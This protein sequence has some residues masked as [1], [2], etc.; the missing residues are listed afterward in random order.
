LAVSGADGSENR[1]Y[2]GDS[3]SC[4]GGDVTKRRGMPFLKSTGPL[5]N[6][7]TNAEGA[8]AM[9]TLLRTF[10]VMTTISAT[11]ARAQ[12]YKLIEA[13]VHEPIQITGKRGNA[14]LVSEADWANIQ[15]TLHLA[16][17]PGMGASIRRG[18]KEPLKKA[19]KKLRW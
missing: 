2:L 19:S 16:A 9:R 14:V 10:V 5:V 4:G 6:G 11:R 13:S 7:S 18:L 8:L 12:L 1:P 3:L 15:E 17:I